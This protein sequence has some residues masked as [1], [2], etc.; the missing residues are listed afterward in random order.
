MPGL[1]LYSH[2][3]PVVVARQSRSAATNSGRKQEFSRK[4]ICAFGKKEFP[5]S[6]FWAGK[7]PTVPNIAMADPR[8][9]FW[10]DKNGDGQVSSDEFS[11]IYSMDYS[12]NWGLDVDENGGVWMSGQS[13]RHF[14]CAGLDSNGVPMYSIATSTIE[15]C[16]HDVT[17]IKY[18]AKDDVMFLGVSGSA[19]PEFSSILCYD[20]WS[21][22]KKLRYTINIQTTSGHASWEDD[23]KPAGFTVA[24]DHLFTG[25]VAI[26]P[27]ADIQPGTGKRGEINVYEVKTGAYIQPI[28]PQKETGY[29][30]GCIDL[31]YGIEALKRSNGEVALLVEEDGEAKVQLYRINTPQ[32]TPAA[33]PALSPECGIYSNSVSITMTTT[34]GAA[35]HY[36][37]DG[38]LPTE[39]SPTYDKPLVVTNTSLVMARGFKAGSL[40]SDV[41]G[42]RLHHSRLG[43]RC[44]A[45]S[46]IYSA[47]D[48]EYVA[49]ES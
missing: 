41:A 37:T 28:F 7:H 32:G 34:D 16:P 15:P 13:L 35:I 45:F 9:W 6:L 29:Y 17:R 31:P 44:N 21:T 46:C 23:I 47:R 43:D 5:I 10:R 48:T 4:R 39:T 20:N 40:P 36:T 3:E 11:E 30:N 19:Y 14:P 24:G 49:D 12:Y 25:Y 38:T 2:I 26:G 1:Q 33:K 22:S 27:N 8:R 18:L 42:G